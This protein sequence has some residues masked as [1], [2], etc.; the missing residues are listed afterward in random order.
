MFSTGK[1]SLHRGMCPV[2]THDKYAI[3]CEV[4]HPP[5]MMVRVCVGESVPNCGRVSVGPPINLFTEPFTKFIKDTIGVGSLGCLAYEGRNNDLLTV[6][7]RMK[8]GR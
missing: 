8:V 7:S 1:G 3:Y 2:V 5:L 6:T 4:S